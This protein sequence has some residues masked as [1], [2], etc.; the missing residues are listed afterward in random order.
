VIVVDS[1]VWIDLFRDAPSP[2]LAELERVVGRERVLVGDLI[3]WEVLQGIDGEAEAKRVETELLRFPLVPM[4][5]ATVAVE[6]ARNYRK[7][8]RLGATVRKTIDVIIGTFCIL[9]DF[10]LLH[11]D[12]DFLP[13]QK[14][15]GLRAL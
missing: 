12:R 6:A 5:G 3:L 7:L 4:L 11:S 15:L 9:N 14:H 10:R 2:A 13:M 8:R 1:T